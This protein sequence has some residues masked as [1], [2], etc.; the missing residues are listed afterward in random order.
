LA[1]S[2]LQVCTKGTGQASPID[3]WTLGQ[4]WLRFPS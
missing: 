3:L 1:I 2:S 4:R